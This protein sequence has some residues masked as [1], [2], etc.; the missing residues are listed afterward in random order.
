MTGISGWGRPGNTGYPIKSGMTLRLYSGQ[1]GQEGTAR[2][3][4]TIKMDPKSSLG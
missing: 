3:S 2:R 1:A 4:P